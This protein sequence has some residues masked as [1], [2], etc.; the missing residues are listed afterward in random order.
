MPNLLQFLIKYGY[1][2]LFGAAFAE[3]L[4]LPLPAVPL[5]VGTGALARTGEF[6]L[7]RIVLAALIGSLIA[8]CVWYRLGWRYGR[9]VLRLV[10]RISLAPDDCIRRTEDLFE[11]R[12]LWALLPAKFVPGLNT[13]ALPLLGMVKTPLLSFVIFDVGLSA[14]RGIQHHRDVFTAIG[15]REE[16]FHR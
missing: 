6:S 3:Q 9:S 5:L 7:S 12:G 14:N 10:C 13:A 11:R 15:A 1:V 2:L 16:I 4:G 8:D